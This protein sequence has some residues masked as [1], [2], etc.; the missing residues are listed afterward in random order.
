MLANPDP[1]L[2]KVRALVRRLRQYYWSLHPPEQCVLPDGSGLGRIAYDDM[3]A[4]NI[5]WS[6]HRP[7]DISSHN[8]AIVSAVMLRQ[9]L[10]QKYGLM[11]MR[12][13]VAF[14]SKDA[15]AVWLARHREAI[16]PNLYKVLSVASHN[17]G[18]F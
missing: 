6:F 16:D 4:F 12:D 1:D 8:K 17:R 2:D 7:N 3:E 5:S 15:F 11:R 9:V 14:L 10:E 13:A 18:S